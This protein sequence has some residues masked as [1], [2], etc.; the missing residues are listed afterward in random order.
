M[1]FGPF[2]SISDSIDNKMK[3]G[4]RGDKPSNTYVVPVTARGSSWV[5]LYVLGSRYASS[6]DRHY[7]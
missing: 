3:E 4:E 1:L 6:H 7:K 5:G 2:F